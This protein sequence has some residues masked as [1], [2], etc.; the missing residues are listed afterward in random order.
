MVVYLQASMSEDQR[1]SCSIFLA[2]NGVLTHL[3]FSHSSECECFCFIHI[4]WISQMKS[5]LLCLDFYNILKGF[6]TNIALTFLYVISWI[7]LIDFRMSKWTHNLCSRNWI[8][9]DI[10]AEFS[11][12]FEKYWSVLFLPCHSFILPGLVLGACWFPIIK[13]F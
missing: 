10:R 5:I 12:L 8:S 2:G 13:V 9:F 7:I 3:D 6:A 1:T 4:G 11:H